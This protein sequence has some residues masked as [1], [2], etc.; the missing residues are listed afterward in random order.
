MLSESRRST[1]PKPDRESA[2]P[3]DQIGDLCGRG[4]VVEDADDDE[5]DF[6]CNLWSE[7]GGSFKPA[8]W[9]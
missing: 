2:M 4:G 1:K 7:D 5:D 3:N 6:I 8:W 9:P